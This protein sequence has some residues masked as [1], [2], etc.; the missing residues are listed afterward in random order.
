[1]HIAFPYTTF[2]QTP[3]SC[4]TLARKIGC[5][6]ALAVA[7]AAVHRDNLV[8]V[9]DPR[10][11]PW[12]LHTEDRLMSLVEDGNC[13]PEVLLLQRLVPQYNVR[14]DKLWWSAI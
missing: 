8:A 4:S 14:Y 10:R 2:Q 5:I 12:A 6:L 3:T 1:M 7:S 11:S 13:Q 9:G